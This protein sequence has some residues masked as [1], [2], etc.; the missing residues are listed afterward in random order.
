MDFTAQ[1]TARTSEGVVVRFLRI[2]FFHRRQRIAP[3]GPSCRRYTTI[4]G[5]VAAASE[6]VKNLRQC[7]V[8][9]PAIKQVPHRLPRPKV[10][11]QIPPW[12]TGSQ[13]PQ[14]T[15]QNRSLIAWWPPHPL[16][17]GKDIRD[18]FPLLIRELMSNQDNSF[19]LSTR[20]LP[21]DISAK[22]QLFRQNLAFGLRTRPSAFRQTQRKIHCEL[23][24][25]IGMM[26][27][28][29]M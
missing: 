18:Q 8:L 25:S 16:G 19:Y 11:R 10:R 26:T 29:I 15:I 5:P 20:V 7:A 9:I 13:D 4:P 3:P 6:A 14:N 28:A 22:L 23:S 17:L 12:R 27:T 24:Q 21:F 2:V 1:T